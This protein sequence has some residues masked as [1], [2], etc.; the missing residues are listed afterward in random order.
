VEAAA[1]AVRREQVKQ[2]IA[3]RDAIKAAKES[4]NQASSGASGKG[5]QKEP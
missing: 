4:Q 1:Q 5:K 3:K 2:E